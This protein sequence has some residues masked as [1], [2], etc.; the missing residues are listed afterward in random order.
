[1]LPSTTAAPSIPVSGIGACFQPQT[2][3]QEVC[4]VPWWLLLLAGDGGQGGGGGGGGPGEARQDAHSQQAARGSNVP[5]A[6]Q[7]LCSRRLGSSQ[8]ADGTA[9]ILGATGGGHCSKAVTAAM[10][11][12]VAAAPPGGRLALKAPCLSGPVK[13]C[14]GWNCSHFFSHT[15]R[16]HKM[17]L[18]PTTSQ[19]NAN[20]LT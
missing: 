9:V 10:P 20:S 3:T 13:R 8:A 11:C 18:L 17:F 14:T 12:S 16:S 1:M 7:G 19:L 6:L 4:M 5:G 2:G 15:A